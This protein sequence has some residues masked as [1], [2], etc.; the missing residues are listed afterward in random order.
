[1]FPFLIGGVNVFMFFSMLWIILNYRVL[2]I[3]YYKTR[4]RTIELG[5]RNLIWNITKKDIR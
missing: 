1:M 2:I 4:D 3:C 5:L